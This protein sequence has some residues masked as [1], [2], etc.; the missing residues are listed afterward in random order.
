MI[1]ALLWVIVGIAVGFLINA[2]FTRLGGPP[3]DAGRTVI[4]GVI[5][6]GLVG[7]SYAQSFAPASA[8]SPR[9]A[10]AA[11]GGAA[12]LILFAKLTRAHLA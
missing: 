10:L 9:E 5:G 11:L 2:G 3:E 4:T 7:S 8:L 1:T 6:A 12:A